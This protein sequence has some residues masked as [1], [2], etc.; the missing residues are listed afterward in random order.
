MLGP[1]SQVQIKEL[2]VPKGQN[3]LAILKSFSI[4]SWF[5]F[6][7][8]NVLFVTPVSRWVIGLCLINLK[9]NCNNEII[10]LLLLNLH[11]EAVLSS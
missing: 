7:V 11:Y 10:I 4:R 8:K 5:T 1:E 6:N 9:P 3:F 2:L